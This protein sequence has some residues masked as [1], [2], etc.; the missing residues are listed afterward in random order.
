M[1]NLIHFYLRKAVLSVG[2]TVI[3]IAPAY[4]EAQETISAKDDYITC[5]KQPCIYTAG[6][7]WSEKNPNGVAVAVA[8][9]KKSA[10]TDDQVKQVIAADLNHY[11]V[12]NIKFFFENYEGVAIAIALHVRGGTEGT[13]GIDTV[14]GEIKNIVRRAK[15]TNPLFSPN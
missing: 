9:G 11:G 6:S 1:K 14:R 10:V 5:W 15:N 12:T 3:F 7:E 8:M 4:S 13:Y 2:L